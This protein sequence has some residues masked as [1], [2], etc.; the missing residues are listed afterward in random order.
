MSAIAEWT[1]DRDDQESSE[2]NMRRW[3]WARGGGT[4][5]ES[6]NYHEAFAALTEGYLD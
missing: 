2:G 6:R 5:D 1:V 4:R 3:S